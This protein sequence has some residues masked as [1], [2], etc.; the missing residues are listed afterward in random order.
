MTET[1]ILK[2]LG[3]LA[4]LRGAKTLARRVKRLL[5]KLENQRGDRS[6]L[7]SIFKANIHDHIDCSV[8]YETILDL[9]DTLYDF[10]F[11]KVTFPESIIS[12]WEHVDFDPT[13]VAFPAAVIEL[14]RSEDVST[15]RSGSR[16]ASLQR[17]ENR[18][19]AVQIYKNFLVEYGGGSLFHYV[20]AIVVHILPIMQ[21]ADTI[22]RIIKE[23]IEDGKQVNG[24]GMAELRGAPQLH[25][26]SDLDMEAATQ[27]YV[28][29]IA[30]APYPV[31][32]TLCAL[33][34]ENPSIAWEVAKLAGKYKQQ[35]VTCF[36]LAADEKSNPGVLDWWLESAVLASLLGI[37]LTI[38][39]WETN[40]PTQQDIIALNSLDWIVPCARRRLPRLA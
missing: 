29:A 4:E 14:W 27:I 7:K 16:K 39:L 2:L 9:W 37:D 6:E 8:R 36:D 10:D 38:H 17:R 25:T 33:R 18:I 32:L 21:R 12:Y 20:Q 24:E 26:W 13:G 5:P 15:E 3:G 19:R 23:R 22:E 35:G 28:K 31:A 40:E 1:D 30:G 11:N 34:H